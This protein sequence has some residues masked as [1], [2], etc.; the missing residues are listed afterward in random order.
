MALLHLSESQEIPALGTL[1][2]PQVSKLAG[3]QE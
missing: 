3:Y 1:C 2:H